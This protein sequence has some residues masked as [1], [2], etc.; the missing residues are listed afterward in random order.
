MLK[1]VSLLAA[2]ALTPPS[3]AAQSPDLAAI[4]SRLERLEQE[5][6]S[7]RQEL[8]A[9]RE[10]IGPAPGAAA[11]APPGASVAS[12]AGGPIDERLDIAEKRI[13]EQAATKVEAGQRYPLRITGMALFNA[14]HGTRQA[15]GNDIFV[16]A[17]APRAIGSGG[18][19]MRQSIIG[20]EFMGPQVLGGA[21]VHG[22][23][24]FDFYNGG[25]EDTL[26]A[27]ARL[28]TG[29]IEL[30]WKRRS[31]LAGQE[32][33][34]FAP[35]DPTSLAYV[36]ISPMTAAGNLWRW[37]PQVRYEERITLG[38]RQLLTAQIGI[39]QTADNI[40]SVP[41]AFAASLERRRPGLEGRFQWSFDF[42]E[43]RRIEIA[44]GFHRSQTHAAAATTPSSVVSIDWFANPWR[45]LEFSGTAWTGQNIAHFGGLRQ[46]VIVRGPG[47]LFSVGSK[48]GWSQTSWLL[49]NRLR[50]NLAAGIHDDR[51]ADLP[52]GGIGRNRHGMAN[53][54]YQFHSNVRVGFEAL[55]IRTNYLAPGLRRVNR[56]DLGIAYLF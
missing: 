26:N 19:S 1:E 29:A 51:D 6:R 39:L 36:G 28:R 13:E 11:A 20:F 14:F 22:F 7:L 37:Q 15:A 25:L 16:T 43:E 41:P 21:T 9:L 4:L 8:D 34:I 40:T 31:L 46:G 18:G 48:G 49:T 27:F 5:N 47:A 54:I 53:L 33:P 32:K 55:Q 12:P 35:R 30:R 42:D 23:A 50:L 17:A 45:R 56:Y 38:E 2:L 3:A 10:R 24:N 44:P 52:A